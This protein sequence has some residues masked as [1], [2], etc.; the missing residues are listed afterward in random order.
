MDPILMLSLLSGLAALT[1]GVLAYQWRRLDAR[2]TELEQTSANHDDIGALRQDLQ[3][4]SN[5]IDAYSQ[6]AD[7]GRQR[8][9]EILLQKVG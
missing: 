1:A 6:R 3:G 9:M 5:K 4:I 7:D 2:V 8:L